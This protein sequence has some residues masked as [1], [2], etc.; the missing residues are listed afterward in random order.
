MGDKPIF[1][2]HKFFKDQFIEF[3]RDGNYMSDVCFGMGITPQA[4]YKW[5]ENAEIGIEPYKSF[6]I[7]V[8]KAQALAVMDKVKN[9]KDA[10]DNGDWVAAMTFLERTQK[11][12]FGRNERLEIKEDK[13]LQVE[14]VGM[15]QEDVELEEKQ[16]GLIEGEIVGT[17]DKV[18]SK[19][20]TS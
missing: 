3:V 18:E 19:R 20:E 13:E 2:K 10:A 5:V 12:K 7:E 6:I 15:N 14:I 9:I 17:E 8:K 11:D 16:K 4:Y 1:E